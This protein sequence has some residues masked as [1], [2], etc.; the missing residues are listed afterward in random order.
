MPD[1]LSFTPA[2][3]KL[4]T[5]WL[6]HTKAIRTH[7]QWLYDSSW[8]KFIWFRCF[9]HK[10]HHSLPALGS[11]GEV[12][13][14]FGGRFGGKITGRAGECEKHGTELDRPLFTVWQW[15]GMS[16]D[17]AHFTES[18]GRDGGVLW[19]SDWV[20]GLLK[21]EGVRDMEEVPFWTLTV[22]Q[23]SAV[24]HFLWCL[25]SVIGVA[26]SSLQ[27]AQLYYI[28]LLGERPVDLIGRLASACSVTCRH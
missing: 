23:V 17:F 26:C 9:L 22:G 16:T 25:H 21:G 1:F 20:W 8:T 10:A 19:D 11:V 3:I 27:L 14:L 28:H 24:H 18:C 15:H 5:F 4:L 12:L 2:I 6:W 7:S 13:A